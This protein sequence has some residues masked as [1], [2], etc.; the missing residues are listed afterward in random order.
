MSVNNVEKRQVLNECLKRATFLDQ[1]SL[2]FFS[3]ISLLSSCLAPFSCFPPV[4]RFSSSF[5][6]QIQNKAQAHA[7]L[8]LIQFLIFH[9]IYIYIFFLKLALISACTYINL[10]FL[11]H[12]LGPSTLSSTHISSI[13]AQGYTMIHS[14]LFFTSNALP[15]HPA[16]SRAEVETDGK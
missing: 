4:I 16:L 1:S 8:M 15:L 10:V 7:W 11:I 9:A 12:M 5:C 3:W 6:L 13:P 14:S 2:F